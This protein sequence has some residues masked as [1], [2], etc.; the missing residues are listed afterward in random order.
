MT[1]WERSESSVSK[2]CTGEHIAI[3]T[4]IVLGQILNLHARTISLEMAN[5]GFFIYHHSAVGDNVER[6][7][8]AFRLAAGRSNVIIVTG[9]LGPT[10]DDLTREA[11]AGYLQRPLHRS[12]EAL[13]EI[14]SYFSHRGRSMPE[15]NKKQALCIE[16]GVLLPNPNGTAPG[17]YVEDHGSHYFLLPG[18]PL[19]MSP[20]LEQE[21]LPRLQSIF[22]R[23][24][25]LTSRVLHLCGI[26]ESTVD[27]QIPHL[28]AGQNPTVAPLAGE[29]EML[30]RITATGETEAAVQAIIAPVESRLQEMFNPYIYGYDEDTLPVVVGRL[31]RESRAT[32]AI[33]ESCTGGMV[34]SMIT[35]VPGSSEYF[36]GGVVAYQNEVKQ[37]FI[38]VQ[39]KTLEMHGAVS[40]ETAGEMADGVRR[41]FG[42][43]YGIAVTGVAG[44]TGGSAEKPVGLVFCGV[45]GPLGTQVFRLQLR[46]SR[47][48]IRLRSVKQALWRLC[49]V[50]RHAQ[51]DSQT[52]TNSL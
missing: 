47:D 48:Q 5:R 37:K 19:E 20:M 25:V 16:G 40:E 39:S 35:A 29:G 38:D 8:D 3:G 28:L 26:G 1:L 30:L 42:S 18:P 24:Y 45:S 49:N 2:T 46:G 22:P 32:V 41:Q 15:E 31:L 51:T 10:A 23:P 9:G 50:I 11:L 21:V 44:P 7:R 13:R 12:E 43:T 4:E 17:Q 34:S 27:E 36:L 6:I 33:A 52:S 14:Q